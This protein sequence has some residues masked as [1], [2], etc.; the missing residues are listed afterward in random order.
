MEGNRTRS[1]KGDK[2]LLPSEGEMSELEVASFEMQTATP[3]IDPNNQQ[4][5]IYTTFAANQ[6]GIQQI[7]FGNAHSYNKSIVC[8]V[9]SVNWDDVDGYGFQREANFDHHQYDEFMSEYLPVMTR[10]AQRW[11]SLVGEGSKINKSRTGMALSE[12]SC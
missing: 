11:D 2:P 10:R 1:M 4:N 6:P 8:F 3:M 9:Y 12:W 7:N 5:V